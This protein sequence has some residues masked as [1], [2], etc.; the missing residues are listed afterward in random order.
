MVCGVE[1]DGP[2][3]G[4]VSCKS[5]TVKIFTLFQEFLQFSYFSFHN[6]PGDP[7]GSLFTFPIV[8]GFF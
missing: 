7:D 5:E 8:W 2:K 6:E 3:K 1:T 4:D